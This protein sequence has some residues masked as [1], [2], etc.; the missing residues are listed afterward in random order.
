[1]EDILEDGYVR[2]PSDH[3]GLIVD[4]QMKKCLF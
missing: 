1:M 2:T 3:M 4:F